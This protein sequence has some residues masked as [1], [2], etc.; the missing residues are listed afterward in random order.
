MFPQ[1]ISKIELS[2]MQFPAFA[3][4]ELD[5]QESLLRQKKKEHAH[6]KMKYLIFAIIIII[7]LQFFVF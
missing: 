1:E 5:N 6:N 7:G 4:L 3:G 2:K